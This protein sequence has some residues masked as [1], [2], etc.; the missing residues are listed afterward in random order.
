M[1]DLKRIMD[2]EIDTFIPPRYYEKLNLRVMKSIQAPKHRFNLS[3]AEKKDNIVLFFMIIFCSILAYFF[4]YSDQ[5]KLSI[6]ISKELAFNFLS[7]FLIG[8]T[9]LILFINEYFDRKKKYCFQI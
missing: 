4:G 2:Q 8:I 7:K 6:Y 9:I 1:S 3:L 5:F